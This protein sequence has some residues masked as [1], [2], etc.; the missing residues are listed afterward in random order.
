MSHMHS[1]EQVKKLCFNIPNRA[2]HISL[3]TLG[4]CDFDP[5]AKG[6]ASILYM[7]VLHRM[8]QQQKK[9]SY[10]QLPLLNQGLITRVANFFSQRKVIERSG[11]VKFEKSDVH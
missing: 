2:F 4:Y 6:K 10:P 3:A 8:T 5:F 7:T 11:K 1:K 9:S